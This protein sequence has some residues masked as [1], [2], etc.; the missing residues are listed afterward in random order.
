MNNIEKSLA[1]P[2]DLWQSTN[3]VGERPMKNITQIS[4]RRLKPL[5]PSCLGRRAWY[6]N[7]R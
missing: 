4:M 6:V 5:E 7:Y 2:V 1:F 3:C